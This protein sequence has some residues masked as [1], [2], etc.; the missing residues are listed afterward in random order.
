M[1]ERPAAA[2]MAKSVRWALAIPAAA[3]GGTLAAAYAGCVAHTCSNSRFDLVFLTVLALAVT[4]AAL[5]ILAWHRFTPAILVAVVPC[6]AGMYLFEAIAVNP[7]DRYR[8]RVLA[9][10]RHHRERGL[11]AVP[12]WTPYGFAA[13]RGVLPLGDGSEV[14]PLTGPSGQFVV[15]CQEGGRPIVGY[16][17]D[18]VGLNNP[19]EAW[20]QETEILFLGDSFT[21]GACVDNAAHFVHAVRQQRPGTINLGYS[22][23]GPLLE[24]AGIREYGRRLRPRFV[25]W[26]YDEA[27]DVFSYSPPSDLDVEIG[28]PILSGYL[29]APDFTQNLYARQSEVNAAVNRMAA[30]WV[31]TA[32]PAGHTARLKQHVLLPSTREVLRDAYVR[33]RISIPFAVMGEPPV[34]AERIGQFA[35]IMRSAAAEVQAWGGRLAVVNLPALLAACLGRDHPSRKAV[36]DIPRQLGV[37][38]IDVE[39]PLFDLARA[40]G[41]NVIAG[42]R[43]CAGHYSEAA[44]AVIAS[45]LMEYLRVAAGEALPPFWSEKT[46]PDGTRQ[47]I[48]AGRMHDRSK[49]LRP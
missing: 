49:P 7:K 10:V 26:M 44:Y 27:N 5:S 46:K 13:G 23:N 24:L 35:Q 32:V 22:G 43:P 11:D 39:G 48:Y 45:V 21:H 16:R 4:I 17:A 38:L 31:T 47:L 29:R 14:V 25:F 18:A 9:E 6:L 42:E 40:Q 36:L 3:I 8:D 2:V 1:R 20:R 15:M 19:P 33:L 30:A 28:H 34:G 37:D 41:A 12:Q